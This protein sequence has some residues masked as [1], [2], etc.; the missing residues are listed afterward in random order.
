MDIDTYFAREPRALPLYR[1]VEARLL[2]A[3]PGARADVQ[4]SQITFR[5]RPALEPGQP[6]GRERTLAAVWLP[7]HPVAGRPEVY[8]VLTFG[9][10]RRIDDSRIVEAVEP[11]PGRWTHHVII[12]GTEDI[13]EQVIAWLREAAGRVFR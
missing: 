13:G 8:V 11:Y 2:A 3:Y 12:A 9:L 10:R 7:I 6:P 5:L 1:A 4:R